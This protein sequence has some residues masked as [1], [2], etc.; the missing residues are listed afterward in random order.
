MG[1]GVMQ[2]PTP[3]QGGLGPFLRRAYIYLRHVQLKPVAEEALGRD[4]SFD[5]V[6]TCWS[7]KR[8][9]SEIRVFIHIYDLGGGVDSKR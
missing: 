7:R 2:R 1:A 4:L 6:W 9:V 5:W 3:D 8:I